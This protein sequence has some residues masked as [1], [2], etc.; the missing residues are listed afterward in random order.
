MTRDEASA[1]LDLPREQAIEL[2]LC[3]AEKAEKFDLMHPEIGPTT[4]SAMTPPYLK[5]ACGKR[6]K[7][8]GRPAGHPGCTRPRPSKVDAVKPH[9]LCHC[10]E[11]G[12]P[13]K[14]SI[15]QHRRLIE[16]IPNIE[17]L[18]TEHVVH[19]YWCSRCKK[20]VTAT[21]TDA[22]PNGRIGLRLIVFTAWLHYLVGVSVDNL[23]S[24]LS[25]LSSVKISAGGLTQAW[26]RLA[27]YLWQNY[28]DLGNQVRQS[29]VLNADETGWRFNGVTHWLW[30]FTTK[31]ICY[32]TITRSRGS[33]VIK[34]V[35]GLLFDGILICDF[36]GAY[37]KI[38]T[39]ATQ[40]CLYH[41]FT[42]LVKVDKHNRS[43]Q[44]KAFR[45]KLS[46]LMKDA[47][48]LSEN[49]QITAQR[50]ERLRAR[51]YVRLE[52]MTS[53]DYLDKDVKRLVKRLKR[54]KKELFI[55]LDYTGVS[56]Y[57]NHAEQQMRKAVLC[58]KVSQQNR[59]EKG[60]VTQAVLMTLFRTAELQKQN[61]L[62]AVLAA[63]KTAIRKKKPD[64]IEFKLA[65]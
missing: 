56:P 59:S 19:G 61:P 46:R 16:D 9:E 58:R 63:A 18:V 55:F 26:S 4:P 20:I 24:M 6:K 12:G 60:T 10:P 33:P 22:F 3:L 41:L 14:K 53:G 44:W 40:R 1:I 39:L 30:C 47:I 38:G 36:W 5:A 28:Q 49:N 13:V 23:V 62:E 8:P 27:W 11:C 32:Y 21:L 25:V 31:T 43:A 45:K 35:L 54:H 51:L 2:I 48:R 50:R 65:A 64:S 7:K 17:P 15:R 52:E 37:N 57:N 29:A 42:E 34:Q